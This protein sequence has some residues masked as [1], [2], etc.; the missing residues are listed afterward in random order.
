MGGGEGSGCY[1]VR[2]T[3][4]V[5]GAHGEGNCGQS[6]VP[7]RWAATAIS[8]INAAMAPGSLRKDGPEKGLGHTA[9]A[10]DNRE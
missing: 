7:Q 4:A 9:I 5:F 3:S 8:F 10:V 6:K 1:N 2:L